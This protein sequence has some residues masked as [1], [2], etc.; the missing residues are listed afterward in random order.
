MNVRKALSTAAGAAAGA[1][2]LAGAYYAQ[3]ADRE[4]PP[5]TVLVTDGV[6]TPGGWTLTVLREDGTRTTA[7]ADPSANDRDWRPGTPAELRTRTGRLGVGAEHRVAPL[8]P[9]RS[10]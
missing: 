1:L 8:P 4:A 7:P 5:E 6:K 3:P 2:V 10:P 9:H